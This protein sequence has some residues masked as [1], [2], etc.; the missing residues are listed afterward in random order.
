[1][2]WHRAG[3][4]AEAGGGARFQRDVRVSQKQALAERVIANISPIEDITE[5]NIIRKIA[6]RGQN[7]QQPIKMK[8]PE[9]GRAQFKHSQH[10]CRRQHSSSMPSVST[11]RGN[12]RDSG[13][14]ASAARVAEIKLIVG[15]RDM[16][17]GS[18]GGNTIESGFSSHHPVDDMSLSQ[19]KL[20]RQT[21]NRSF[22]TFSLFK[23]HSFRAIVSRHKRRRAA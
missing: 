9:V 17:I 13:I 10:G 3:R 11:H 4:W 5:K 23:C 15:Q 20:K 14:I 8:K 7:E 6:S 2:Q 18:A 19:V 12:E 22:C 21:A 1:M 16:G